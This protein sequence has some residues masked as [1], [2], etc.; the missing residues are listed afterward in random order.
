MAEM[1]ANNVARRGVPVE[2][3]ADPRGQ[4]HRASARGVSR[5]GVPVA[6]ATDDQG[7]SRSSMAGEYMRA[8][9]DQHLDVSPAQD[10][11]AQQPRARVPAGREPVDD[12]SAT[13]VAACA[14]TDT[15]G[16]GDTPNAACAAFL[17]GS[18]RAAMQ[19]KLEGRFLAFE[20]VQ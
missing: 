12:D 4:R 14:P 11:R 19:W 1:A 9:L 5:A 20:S 8:A 13:P 17:A 2:Q 3:R 7:V 18:E 15:M 16:I 10:D 6:L